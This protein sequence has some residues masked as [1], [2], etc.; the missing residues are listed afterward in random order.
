M[1]ND[2]GNLTKDPQQFGAADSSPYKFSIAI[3]GRRRKL[4]KSYDAMFLDCVV[5]PG[6]PA[7][8]TI[9][10]L[11]ASGHPLKQ[12]SKIMPTYKLKQEERENTKNPGQVY[13]NTF[14]EV[15][16]IELVS[17]GQRNEGDNSG[18]SS[19]ARA[20]RSNEPQNSPDPEPAGDENPVGT[21]YNI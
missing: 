1:S 4:D 5:F 6:T 14:A 10:R 19:G 7:F 20:G 3:N 12:G 8:K 17:S 21:S 15:Y 13:V 18:S 11:A 16:D 2:V 9:E